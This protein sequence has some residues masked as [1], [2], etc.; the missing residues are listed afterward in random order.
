MTEKRVISIDST[1]LNTFQLC[2][3]KAQY[4]FE[5]HLQ[6]PTKAEPLERGDLLHKMMEL[7]YGLV[8]A[9]GDQ[10]V[11]SNDN[12]TIVK[13]ADAGL[14]TSLNEDFSDWEKRVKFA[15]EAARYFAT[16]MELGVDEVEETIFQFGAY[17]KHFQYDTW[18]PL[19]VEEVGSKKIYEDEETIIVY[20]F[21]IDV[22]ME[23][24]GMVIPWD[25]KTSKRSQYPSS[26]S[27]QF[28]GYAFGVN[29]KHV[30]VNKIGFQKTK[31]PSERFQR[32]LLTYEAERIEE[33]LV[34]TIWWTQMYD[35]HRLTDTW[36]MNLTSCDK[37]SGCVY[38]DLCE[39][40]ASSRDWIK[41][42][43]YIVGQAWDVASI[44]E[45]KK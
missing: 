41:E 24:D 40:G 31:S 4:N 19:A 6:P 43:Q 16:K 14:I 9:S 10:W 17:A 8:F 21:K 42:R 23:K 27:N 7:Y 29:A 39:K 13:L 35:H 15:V 25:H 37:Y 12:D 34:N 2:A 45:A 32:D 11:I 28:I 44:L 5:E 30:I 38:S 3:R 18:M 20:N 36:P 26:L 1:I 33:W 22:I